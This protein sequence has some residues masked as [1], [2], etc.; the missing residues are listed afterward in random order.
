MEKE[1]L[2][3]GW[4]WKKIKD[5]C[6]VVSGSTPKTSVPDYWGGDI[7]WITPKD[8]SQFEG[9]TIYNTSRK[10]TKK[11]YDSCSTTLLPKGSVLMSSRA[12]IGLL[13]I[14][15]KEICTNQG[16]KSFVCSD[17][18]YN[19]YLY[20]YLKAI[21]PKIKYQGSGATFSE[22]SKTKVENIKIVIPPLATQQEIVAKLDNQMAEIERI[23]K[24]AE[25]ELINANSLYKSYLIKVFENSG[26]WNFIKIGDIFST[27]YG[28]SKSS[29]KD[30]SKTSAL[31]MNN[32]TYEGKLV[33]DNI[34]YLDLTEDEFNK[35]KL[36]RQDLL[37]NRTNSAELVGK[38]TVFDKDEDYVAVSYLIVATPKIKDINSKFI[39]YYLNTPCMKRYF[40]ENCN[41]AISQA[42]FNATKLSN[43]KVPVPDSET[44]NI[45]V[46]KIE[47]ISIEIDRL[48]EFLT[49]QNETINQL[50]A[51]ILN[52]VFGK[53]EIPEEV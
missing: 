14:A 5:I 45:V 42:N 26:N 27:R 21:M 3:V 16:F 1:K 20:Y 41:R 29:V 18:I 19:K 32:I 13:A 4:E 6:K 44:Q 52:E 48:K 50:P 25:N 2:P 51:S 38:T 49:K 34:T 23:K 7:L 47:G 40:F 24:E 43:I 46:N 9:N 35:H 36:K 30:S 31:R 22:I 8:L 10:I 17:S 39:S 37:F 12:P 33:T 15:G 28:I 53:Y 11:G